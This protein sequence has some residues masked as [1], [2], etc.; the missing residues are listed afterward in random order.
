M[1]LRAAAFSAALILVAAACGDDST[2][3]ELIGELDDQP[4]AT[5]PADDQAG[6]PAEDAGAPDDQVS[7]DPAGDP[8]EDEPGAGLSSDEQAMMDQ[9]SGGRD[10]P[11][12]E[13]RCLLD[14]MNEAGVDPS[15]VTGPGISLDDEIVVS[16]LILSCF[17]EPESLLGFVANFAQGFSST[18]GFELSPDQTQCLVAALGDGDFTFA[19]LDGATLPPA[20]GQAFSDCLDLDESGLFEPGDAYGDNPV[21]D[22]LWDACE[23]G[24]DAACDE[25]YSISEVGSAYEAFGATCGGRDPDPVGGACGGAFAYGDDPGL[26]LLWDACEAG[27]GAACDDLFFQSAIGS[28][29]EDFGDTCGYRF[30]QSPGLCEEAIG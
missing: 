23:N 29:Y 9:L 24:D 19:D 5:Q 11:D 14:G 27:D 22:I 8:P 10:M 7:E 2:L 6:E 16:D 1:H 12:D 20:L 17:E 4:A 26:D 28:I 25:L 3:A 30:D 15:V 21:L 18:A 13:V